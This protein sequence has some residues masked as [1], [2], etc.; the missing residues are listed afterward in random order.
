MVIATQNCHGY[1]GTFALLGQTRQFFLLIRTSLEEELNIII[2]RKNQNPI[3]NVNSI[4]SKEEIIYHI[5]SV[6][7]VD[8]DRNILKYI[9]AL[10]S[11]TRQDPMIELGAS[12]R[13]SISLMRAA[14]G[15]AYIKGRSYVVPEDVIR[16]ISAVLSHRIIL[17]QGKIKKLL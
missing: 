16:V 5:D 17:S 10:V 15:Y 8:V 12:P 14:Q 2:D 6:K 7:N 1:V 3:N 9:V 11:K 4:L 13:A